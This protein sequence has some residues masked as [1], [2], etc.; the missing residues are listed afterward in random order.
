M[1]SV[2]DKVI[3]EFVRNC[4]RGVSLEATVGLEISFIGTLSDF[5]IC[6]TFS[7]TSGIMTG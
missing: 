6:P 1:D 2:L 3:L 7:G 4:A 5:N